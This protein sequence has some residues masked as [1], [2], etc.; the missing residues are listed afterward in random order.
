VAPQVN[1]PSGQ[2]PFHEWLIEF[3]NPPANEEAFAKAL[4]DEMMVQNIY[5]QDLIEGKILQ[6]LVVRRLPQG[7]FKSYMQSIGKLGG[8]NKVPRLCN[9]RS[10][11][12]P[13]VTYLDHRPKP[14]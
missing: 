5:Y 13:L 14:T 1:P 11:A 12:D 3:G 6:P 10:L 9:D 2:K 4:N 8:Q 7:S